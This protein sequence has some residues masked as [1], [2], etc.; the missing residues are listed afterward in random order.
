MTK[1]AAKVAQYTET[2]SISTSSDTYETQNDNSTSETTQIED[3]QQVRLFELSKKYSINYPWLYYNF[4]KGGYLCKICETFAVKHISAASKDSED[5]L[6]V[7]LAVSWASG[8]GHPKRK[9]EKHANSNRHKV[10]LDK[11]L[12]YLT[13][14]QKGSVLQQLKSEASKTS[15]KKPSRNRDYIKKTWEN[16]IF[17]SQ[18]KNGPIQ[19][20]W[21]I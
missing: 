8:G 12:G 21:K 9:L 7:D 1:P 2:T 4:S 5:T 18:K 6:F 13:T 15:E 14:K 19:I 20:T 3:E 10:A 17:D 11:Q 16:V